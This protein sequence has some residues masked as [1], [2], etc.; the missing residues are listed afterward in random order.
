MRSA[1]LLASILGINAFASTPE[2][3]TVTGYIGEG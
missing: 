3:M 1:L 2:G